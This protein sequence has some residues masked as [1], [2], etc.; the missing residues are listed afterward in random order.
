ML[1]DRTK[2]LRGS[3]AAG[4]A[5]TFAAGLWWR[6]HP[7]P[8]PYALRLWVQVPH[9]IINRS[10]LRRVLEP[11]PGERILEIGP[12]TGYYTLGL[13]Q[14]I[15]DGELELL[16]IQSEMLEHTMRKV[17]ARG[18]TNVSSSQADATNL[19]YE[20]RS[21][22]AALLVTVFGEI[23]DGDA[24]LREVR[25]VLKPGG[26]LIIGEIVVGDPHFSRLSSL[27]A[28]A[29]RAGLAPVGHSGFPFAYF[30]RFTRPAGATQ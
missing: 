27:R 10:R 26:R 22:D 19:P 5:A 1:S 20:D 14:W 17:R 16:D 25:R 6:K 9:P 2:W 18:L 21:F 13:A 3:L 29:E 28:R 8:C 7:S 15:G 4:V 23:P 11:R 30:A 24:A 12:G